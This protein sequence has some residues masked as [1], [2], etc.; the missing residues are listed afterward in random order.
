MLTKFS[1]PKLNILFSVS[2]NNLTS[3]IPNCSLISVGLLQRKQFPSHIYGWKERI[4]N[5]AKNMITTRPSLASNHYYSYSVTGF[6][7][8]LEKITFLQSAESSFSSHE[9]SELCYHCCNAQPLNLTSTFSNCLCL[10][11]E[12]HQHSTY[13]S[14]STSKGISSTA[15]SLATTSFWTEEKT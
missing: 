1:V 4:V 10:S 2:K 9:L 3:Q 13:F 5:K 14:P 7:K 11:M 6:W 15:W 12:A 8:P